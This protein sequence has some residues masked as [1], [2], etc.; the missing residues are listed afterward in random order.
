MWLVTRVTIESDLASCLDRPWLDSGLQD[1]S[2]FSS[3]E[4]RGWPATRLHEALDRRGGASGVEMVAG[5]FLASLTARP[6]FNVTDSLFRH[7]LIPL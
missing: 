4:Y 3:A 1:S 7:L 5:S 2:C 6:F